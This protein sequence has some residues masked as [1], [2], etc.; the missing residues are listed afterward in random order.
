MR[1]LISMSLL[2]LT[3]AASAA[4]VAAFHAAAVGTCFG[5]DTRVVD[6]DG[7][8][9]DFNPIGNMLMFNNPDSPGML[10]AVA[11]ILGDKGVRTPM[12]LCSA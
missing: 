1:L 3:A 7:L 8:E 10:R 11:A 5:T 4:A 2:M 6:V 12:K 9:I